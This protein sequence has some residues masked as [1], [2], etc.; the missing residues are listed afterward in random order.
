MD[1]Q[2]TKMVGN[3]NDFTVVD[4]RDEALRGDLHS[5][6]ARICR[7]KSSIGADGVL[8]LEKDPKLPF[9]MRYFNSDGSEAEMCGNGARCIAL[10]AYS[11]G[12]APREML[13]SSRAG[14][15]SASVSENWVRLKFTEPG[16]VRLDVPLTVEGKRVICSLLNSG[17]PHAV[18]F[19][20]DLAGE[21]VTGLGRGVRLHKEFQ[22]QGTNVDFV[23][24]TGGHSIKIRTYE[25][26][27]E[28]ETLSCGTGAVASAVISYL[29]GEVGPA[30]EVATE[31]GSLRVDFQSEKEKV[32]DVYLEGE[33]RIVYEG[34]IR[35]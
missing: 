9:S 29:K 28:G 30:V 25:R 12:I 27:V 10:Y 7:R 3:G 16:E 15:H 20:Q 14:V 5:I 1:M 6:L 26:G 21:D 17:V 13:F 31:G 2:F 33:A 4:N 19:T 24:V 8:L 11:K 18:I 23:Q 32:K 22:P 35:L 34:R